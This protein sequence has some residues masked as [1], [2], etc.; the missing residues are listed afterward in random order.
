MILKKNL[1]TF[2]SWV[3]GILT[4]LKTHLFYDQTELKA[5]D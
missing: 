2:V 1:F 5:R 4:I 3:F